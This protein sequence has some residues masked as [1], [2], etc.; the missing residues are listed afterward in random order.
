MKIAVFHNLPSGGGKRALYNNVNFLAKDHEVDVFIPSTANEE[1]LPL[2][3]ITDSIKVFPVKN[4]VHGFLF[5]LIK[6]F[7]SRTSL[8]DLEKTQKCIAEVVNNENYDVVY[9]EQDQH[10][11]AP[12]FLKYIEKAHVYYCAQP[13]NFRNEISKILY[14][15][16]ELKNKNKNETLLFRFFGEKMIKTDKKITNYSK[17]TVV[18]SYFSRESILKNYGINSFVSYLGVDTNLFKPQEIQKEN[19]VLSVGQCIPSKGY[20][21]IINSL[22]KIDDKIRPEFVIVSDQGNIHWKNYL[23]ELAIK[24]SVKLRILTMIDDEELIS[25]YNKAILVVYAPYL[26]P[27]G[28]VPLEAMSCGTPVVAVKEGGVRESV[29]HNKT[30]ILTER[31]DTLFANEIVEL[32]LNTEKSEELTKNS[33]KE[34]N[35]FWTLK[36]SGKRLLKHLNRSITIFDDFN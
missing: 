36:D 30:G 33:I 26:E 10:T 6:Y 14:E 1:Y 9:C 17:Y 27:F 32:I 35:N 7:P 2:K 29:I 21:F 5:S 4:T 11:M 8:V 12:F 16:A 19:F 22:S 13:I 18:N 20:E 34:V 3:N 28:L 23:K 15:N 31:D 25:L 24:L